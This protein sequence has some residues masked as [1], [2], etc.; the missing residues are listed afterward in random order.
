MNTCDY[1]KM[2]ICDYLEKIASPRS[3]RGIVIKK[4][5]EPGYI[6]QRVR[7]KAFDGNKE[8]GTSLVVIKSAEGDGP[9]IKGVFVDPKHRGKGISSMLMSAIE[10]DYKGKTIR[11]R[12]KPYKDKALNT[13]KLSS[14]YAKRGYAPYDSQN[15]MFK[16]ASSGLKK[17]KS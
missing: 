6:G 14:I 16:L 3:S 17:L 1:L 11:L 5:P 9:W 4:V 2:N 12:A 10:T 13:K 8:L 15:R 7:Y